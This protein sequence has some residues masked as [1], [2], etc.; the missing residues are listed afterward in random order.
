MML[1]RPTQPTRAMIMTDNPTRQRAAPSF[2]VTYARNGKSTSP[3]AES[4]RSV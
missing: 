1:T 3:T 4:E 2:A